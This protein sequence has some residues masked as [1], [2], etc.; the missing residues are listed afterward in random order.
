MFWPYDLWL[1][2]GLGPRPYLPGRIEL[3]VPGRCLRLCITLYVKV[4]FSTEAE[5]TESAFATVTSNICTTLYLGAGS[6]A[7]R[8]LGGPL[9]DPEIGPLRRQEA[10]KQHNVYSLRLVA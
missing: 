10:K 3:P 5:I 8:G 6:V 1:K 2:H 4:H 7:S 9:L